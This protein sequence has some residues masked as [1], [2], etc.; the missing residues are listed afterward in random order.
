[1]LL[2]AARIKILL[3]LDEPNIK[4]GKLPKPP[5]EVTLT[6]PLLPVPTTAVIVLSLRTLYELALI[7][8][9]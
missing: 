3:E 7:P 9:K 1:M 2:S 4:P 8:P 5:L 6:L